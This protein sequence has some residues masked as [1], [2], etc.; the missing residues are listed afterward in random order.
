MELI[1][2]VVAYAV[3]IFLIAKVKYIA[4][5]LEKA[6]ILALKPIDDIY[7]AVEKEVKRATV[8]IIGLLVLM[9]IGAFYIGLFIIFIAALIWA[10]R[11]IF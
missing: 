11:I 7:T 6:T 1:I 10:L 2:V 4:A 5:V 3:A 9:A 8:S